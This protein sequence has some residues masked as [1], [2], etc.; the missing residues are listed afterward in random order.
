M[1]QGPTWTFYIWGSCCPIISATR[2]WV[3]KESC[4]QLQGQPINLGIC[5]NDSVSLFSLIRLS[6]L[7]PD[8]VKIHNIKKEKK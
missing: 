1:V 4:P 2:Q 6:K 8:K 3:G 7:M 5:K